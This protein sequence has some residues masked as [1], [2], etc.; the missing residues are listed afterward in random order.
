MIV[1]EDA[2]LS[3]LVLHAGRDLGKVFRMES[4]QFQ[5]GLD[6]GERPVFEGLVVGDALGL[7]L[8]EFRERDEKGKFSTMLK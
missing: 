1:E 4:V 3:R 8:P 7:H 5:E 6:V 2:L